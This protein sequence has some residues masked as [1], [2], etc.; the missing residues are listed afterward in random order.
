[1][2]GGRKIPHL[3]KLESN[4]PNQPSLEG[5]SEVDIRPSESEVDLTSFIS[6]L[7]SLRKSSGTT[8]MYE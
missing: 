4:D 6:L 7:T 8:T 1:M 5:K 2:F 3:F